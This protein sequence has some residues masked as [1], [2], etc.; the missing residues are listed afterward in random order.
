MN[1]MVK[2]YPE[3][4]SHYP[5]TMQIFIKKIVNR[6]E[7][8]KNALIPIVGGTGSGKSFAM[9]SL[10]IGIHLY[11]KGD[12]PTP[13]YIDEHTIF[14]AKDLMIGLNRDD[15]TEKEVWGWDEVGIDA[16][17]KTSMSTKNKVI[18]WLAQTF[19]NLRQIVFFTVPTIS[20]IDASIR[21]L[22]HYYLETVTIDKNKSMCIIKPLQMQYNP[23]MDK[24]YYHNL[25]FP[26]KEG[27][28]EVIDLMA[29]PK[30]PKEFCDIYESNKS[31]FTKA[32]NLDIQA[33]LERI[34]AK[35]NP[36]RDLTP[37]QEKIMELLKSG[38]TSTNEIAQKIGVHSSNISLNF[39]YMRK[40]GLNVDFYLQKQGFDS[41]TSDLPAL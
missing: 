32:L 37:R 20:F 18:G 8:G 28:F 33:T 21:K 39:E 12:M 19:R 38:V 24:V 7:G 35:E 2:H 16:G 23:R 41:I 9:L 27:M 6:V 34:D 15:L 17:H 29:V 40:K 14:K 31:K 10:M 4:I 1:K 13:E 36:H 11:M 3:S 5:R 26:D 22:L 25:T 30:P